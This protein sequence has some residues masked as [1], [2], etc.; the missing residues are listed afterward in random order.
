MLRLELH[1]V[2]EHAMLRMFCLDLR[3]AAE[4]MCERCDGR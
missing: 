3:V 1:V 4:R 2:L